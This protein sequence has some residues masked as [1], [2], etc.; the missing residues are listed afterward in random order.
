[1]PA[2]RPPNVK[3]S[4][5]PQPIRLSDIQLDRL[6]RAR[7]RDGIGIQE[8]IRRG[9]DAYLGWL[10][11]EAIAL[12]RLDPTEQISAPKTGVKLADLSKRSPRARPARNARAPEEAA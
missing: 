3:P 10:E 4:M 9:I 12:G 8:H 1:M 6:A 7:D 2:G 5:K 11:K